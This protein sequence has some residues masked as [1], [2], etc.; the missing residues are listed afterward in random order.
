MQEGQPAES[1]TL[2]EL[3]FSLSRYSYS[4][5]LDDSLGR[6]DEQVR[7]GDADVGLPGGEAALLRLFDQLARHL[8]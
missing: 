3:R 4:R 8:A 6:Q 1:W 7:S 5:I 2:L